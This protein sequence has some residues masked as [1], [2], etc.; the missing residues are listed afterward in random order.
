MLEAIGWTH[1]LFGSDYPTTSFEEADFLTQQLDNFCTTQEREPQRLI[2]MVNREN[3]L[4]LIPK[5]GKKALQIRPR[6]NTV[7][8]TANHYLL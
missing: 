8:V 6:G 2:Q 4:K 3:G 5:C 1:T 7:V